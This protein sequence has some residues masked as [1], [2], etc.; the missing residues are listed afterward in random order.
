MLIPPSFDHGRGSY[1]ST[2]RDH[3]RCP[4]NR[5]TLIDAFLPHSS[6]AITAI[7]T[8]PYIFSRADYTYRRRGEGEGRRRDYSV[9]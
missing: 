5:Y 7:I 6:D 9:E 1:L 3:A 2:V 8:G 4:A